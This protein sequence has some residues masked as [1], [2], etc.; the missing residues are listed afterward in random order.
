MGEAYHGAVA[1]AFCGSWRD[2]YCRFSL[3]WAYAGSLLCSCALMF[4]HLKFRI[5]VIHPASTTVDQGELH[6]V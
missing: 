2:W 3:S 5:A 1:W 4:P 6:L